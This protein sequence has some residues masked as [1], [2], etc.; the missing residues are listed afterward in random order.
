LANW[1][2][3][4]SWKIP[5]LYVRDPQLWTGYKRTTAAVFAIRFSDV[6]PIWY[7]TVHL[8]FQPIKK[9]S[10]R[11]SIQNLSKVADPGHKAEEFSIKKDPSTGAA[12]SSSISSMVPLTF[13]FEKGKR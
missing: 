5:P 1:I 10:L 8:R 7:G 2:S 11:C 3:V 6:K 9:T 12:S 4:I 13:L